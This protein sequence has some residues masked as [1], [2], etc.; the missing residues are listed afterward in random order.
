[1]KKTVFTSKDLPSHLDENAKFSLWQEIHNDQ[2]WTVEYSKASERPFEADIEA[3][4]VGN[5]VVGQM[6][7]A[8]KQAGRTKLHIAKDGH[9]G[10]LL[11]VNLGV[12]AL[13]GSQMGREYRL[14]HGEAA[15]VS[16]SEPLTM[17]GGDWNI[18]S[19]LVIP[20]HI[21][22]AAF[23]NIDNKLGITIGASYE[24]LRLLQGYSRLLEDGAPL[25]SPDL[26]EHAST[27]L[28]DLVGLATGAKGEVAELAAMRGLRV[29]RLQAVLNQIARRFTDV[30]FSTRDVATAQGISV[31]YVNDL[32]QESGLSFSDRVLELRLQRARA[33]LSDRRNDGMRI[34]DIAYAS[35]FADISHFNRGFR[36]R[37]GL[38]PTGAR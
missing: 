31:R 9:D 7:G 8:I 19:N 28:L 18:W 4:P 11:L 24:P 6:A 5:L 16:A 1:M 37:F 25:Q 33:M 15:L 27:T 20:S 34:G 10:H 35:G 21:L 17:T 2:I 30:E 38:T 29:A 22:R 13:T 36:R 26:I 23:G 14:A 3:L 32:L 12:N